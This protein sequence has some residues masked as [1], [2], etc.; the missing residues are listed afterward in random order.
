MA[1]RIQRTRTY[2]IWC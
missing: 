1:V 2:W